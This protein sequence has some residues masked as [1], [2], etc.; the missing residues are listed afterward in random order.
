MLKECCQ[1]RCSHFTGRWTKAQFHDLPWPLSKEA[2]E[3][4]GEPG[5]DTNEAEPLVAPVTHPGGLCGIT[6]TE[7]ITTQS[8]RLQH[9]VRAHPAGPSP[10]PC[11]VHVRSGYQPTVTVGY[12]PALSGPRQVPLCVLVNPWGRQCGYTPDSD[13][14]TTPASC[15]PPRPGASPVGSTSECSLNGPPSLHI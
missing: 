4:G 11:L 14:R 3:S 5:W 9:P 1:G 15:L 7:V 6:T 10:A 13:H 2:A 12:P 8:P